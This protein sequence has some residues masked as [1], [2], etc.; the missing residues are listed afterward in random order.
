MRKFFYTVAVL[1]LSVIFV[2]I[3]NAQSINEKYGQ[4]LLDGSSFGTRIPAAS[5]GSLKFA[6]MS[7]VHI[8]IGANSEKWTAACVDDVNKNPDIQFV[9][10]SGDIANFGSDEEI[11]SAKNIFDALEKPWFIIPGNHDATWSESGTNTFQKVFGY[12]RFEFEAGDIKFL[13]TPCGPNIRM[14]PA[15]I[16][17]ESWIWLEEQINSM[18]DSQPL[19]FVNHYPLDT[20]L[21]KYNEVIELLKKKNIQMVQSGHWHSNQAMEYE[22]IPGVIVR[23]TQKDAKREPG[24]VICDIRGSL[25]SFS[26]KTVGDANPKSPWYRVRMSNGPAYSKD[27]VYPHPINKFNEEFP[28]VKPLWRYE[29]NADIG[30]AAAIYTHRDGDLISMDS[31]NFTQKGANII[32]YSGSEVKRGDLVIFAD[33]AGKIRALNALDG[34]LVWEYTTE[35]KIFSSPAVS[36][37]LVVVGSTDSYI[38]CLTADKGT[39]KWRVKCE[40]SVIGSATIYNGVVYIGAS[41]G[42]FRALDLKS[43]K[44]KWVYNGLKGAVVS[45]PFVDNEQVVIGDWANRVY[46]FSTS[47]GKVQ[48]IWHTPRSLYNFAAAQVWPIKSNGKIIVVCPDRFSYQID[49]RTGETVA[50]NY[51]GREAIGLALDGNSYYIKSMK[52]T[53][54]CISTI[55]PVAMVSDIDPIASGRSIPSASSSKEVIQEEA[56]IKASGAGKTIKVSASATGITGNSAEGVAPTG[57]AARSDVSN[58]NGFGS[59]RLQNKDKDGKPIPTSKVL[60]TSMPGYNYEIGPTPITSIAGVGKDNAGLIFIATDKGNIFALNALDGSL[61]FRHKVSGALINYIMPIGTTQ[62]LVS[63]MDGVVALLEY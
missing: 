47:N 52:D 16:P 23:S 41:D 63:T 9:I 19:F 42:K 28:N 37:G 46:S 38:Y 34:S 1:L 60:W 21:L 43:G 45:K 58:P 18:S 6:I 55:L 7:D 54:K 32:P 27:I 25:I 33:E 3:A 17:R 24:Y 36:K 11:R 53:V 15:L 13:G 29:N 2:N 39:L 51:G 20:S 26:E 35:G 44:I 40:K 8:S 30:C 5:D 59:E 14:A 56:P 49:A 57:T 62:L 31:K 22:G 50:S 10:I 61:A 12:E 48:W 4:K